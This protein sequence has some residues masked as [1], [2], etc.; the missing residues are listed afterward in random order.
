MTNPREV[1]A[2]LIATSMAAA[3]LA[4]EGEGKP[5]KEKVVQE[6]PATT[7]TRA[8][9]IATLIREGDAFYQARDREGMAHKAIDTYC[10]VL[11]LDETNGEACWKV[12]KAHYW[13]GTHEPEGSDSRAEIL[14]EGIEY[15][16]MGVAVDAKNIAAHFWL[17]VMY[18]SYGQAVGMLQS[19]HMAEP[20]KKEME[21]VVASDETF[22]EGGA[23]RVLGRVYAK[24]PGFKGG[25]KKLAKKHLLRAIEL[26]PTNTLNH[27]FL[28]E[29][30]LE[31]NNKA[32]ARRTLET[33]IGL[34]D[35]PDYLPECKGHK[36]R[37]RKLLEENGGR[38]S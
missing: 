3:V 20:I 32:E 8:V 30:Y 23:H 29:L 24:L 5:E 35:D 19:L 16:K 34:P 36:A 22:E 4:Q 1:L 28:A 14:K 38:G 21:W 7:P 17:G 10:K 15:A 37:A 2:L 26:G 25:D 12:A 6:K 13:L 18:G 9:R 31:E 27:L 33:L 11:A